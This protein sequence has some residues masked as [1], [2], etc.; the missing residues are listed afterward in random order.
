MVK[1]GFGREI[2]LVTRKKKHPE[3]AFVL[4]QS[5]TVA[6]VEPITLVGDYI[7]ATSIRL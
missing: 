5:V 6:E 2:E 4:T 7:L 3:G 1:M